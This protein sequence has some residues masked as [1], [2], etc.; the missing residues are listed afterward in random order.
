VAEFLFY[1]VTYRN[2]IKVYICLTLVHICKENFKLM[3]CTDYWWWYG[4][5][6]TFV[7]F[8]LQCFINNKNIK[9]LNF[10]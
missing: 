6:F 10:V 9:N 2:R 7:I 1:I 5:R 8:I 3:L 4:I